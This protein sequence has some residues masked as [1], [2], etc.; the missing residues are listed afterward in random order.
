MAVAR[1]WRLSP[2]CKARRPIYGNILNL[3]PPFLCKHDLGAAPPA[4]LRCPP[5]QPAQ[6]G[7]RALPEHC[8]V[9]TTAIL[10]SNTR[11][12]PRLLTALPFHLLFNTAVFGIRYCRQCRFSR[13]RHCAA[14]R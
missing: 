3:P 4:T 10:N 5:A 14:F 12:L 9:S 7:C 8:L 2:V 11:I 13:G 6:G 1:W